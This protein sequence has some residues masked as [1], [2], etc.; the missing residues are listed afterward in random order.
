MATQITSTDLESDIADDI[1]TRLGA[2]CKL[3]GYTSGD[4]EVF[5]CDTGTATKNTG[6][7]PDSV[8]LTS[9]SDDTNAT[10]GTVSYCVLATSLDAE[11]IRFTDPVNDIGLS[12]ASVTAS[13]TVSV[14]SLSVTVPA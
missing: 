1:V 11:I 5:T 14:T 10:G 9:L 12:S 8:D 13:D 4:V 2:N 7:S 6:T 3:I